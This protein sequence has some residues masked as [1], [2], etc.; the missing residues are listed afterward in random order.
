MDN[1]PKIN[2]LLYEAV[3]LRFEAIGAGDEGLDETRR[4]RLDEVGKLFLS[5]L[6]SANIP[7]DQERIERI[8]SGF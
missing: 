6:R 8:F 3:L 7:H 4:L 2:A 5:G 1:D